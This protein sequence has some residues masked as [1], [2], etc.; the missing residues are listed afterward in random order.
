MSEVTGVNYGSVL[1]W[2]KEN[3]S[4]V[5]TEGERKAKRMFLV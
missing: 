3:P 2:L 1:N 5:R 4:K